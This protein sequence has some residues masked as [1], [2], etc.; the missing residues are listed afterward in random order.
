M[1]RNVFKD[2]QND[3]LLHLSQI[4]RTCWRDE[5]APK[6]SAMQYFQRFQHHRRAASAHYQYT[7]APLPEL[8][9]RLLFIAGLPMEVQTMITTQKIIVYDDPELDSESIQELYE[10]SFATKYI[11]YILLLI[12][13]CWCYTHALDVEGRATVRAAP[14]ARARRPARGGARAPTPY[15]Q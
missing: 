15:L 4:A 14:I 2:T 6:E 9:M 5:R 7:V 11:E 8:S 1:F 12:L 3:F 13:V 10:M